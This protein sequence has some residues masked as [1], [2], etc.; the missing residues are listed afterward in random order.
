MGCPGLSV[1]FQSH[2]SSCLQDHM[3]YLRLRV[4]KNIKPLLRFGGAH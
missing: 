2:Q 1:A 4:G 3:V